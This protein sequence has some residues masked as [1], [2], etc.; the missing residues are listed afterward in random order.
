MDELGWVLGALGTMI[1]SLVAAIIALRKSRVETKK[2]E[3]DYLFSQYKEA[4]ERVKKE[5]EEDR[6]LLGALQAE[7]TDCREKVARLQ[8]RLSA[9]ER[10]N[11]PTPGGSAT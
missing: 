6:I 11:R 7:H 8:E 3:T 1:T 9:L 2:A 4:V 10:A 5:H